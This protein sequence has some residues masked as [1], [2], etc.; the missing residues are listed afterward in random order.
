MTFQLLTEEFTVFKLARIVTNND[1]PTLMI[2]TLSATSPVLNDACISDEVG[3]TGH[4]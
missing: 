2:E 4:N 3:G 1:V